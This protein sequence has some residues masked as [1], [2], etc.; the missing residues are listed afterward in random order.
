MNCGGQVPQHVNVREQDDYREYRCPDCGYTI[1]EAIISTGGEPASSPRHCPMSARHYTVDPS[2][3]WDTWEVW[4]TNI[5]VAVIIHG[6]IV[7]ENAVSA[8]FLEF[9][10][11]LREKV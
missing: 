5:N 10:S 6:R 7:N 2:V 4:W 3:S 11:K 8:D 9:I 1:A